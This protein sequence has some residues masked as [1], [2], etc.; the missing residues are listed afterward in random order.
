M[1][2]IALT[3]GWTWWHIYPLLALYNYLKDDK[4]L[5]FIWVWEQDSLEE[6][7]ASKAWIP[8]FDISAWKVRRYLDL[9]NLYEPLKNTSWV[10]QWVQIIKRQNIDLVFS[11]WWYVGLPLCIAAKLLWK[12]IY[13]HESDVITWATNHLIWNMAKKIFYTFPNEKIDWKKHILSGQ[14]INPEILDWLEDVE[15]EEN[16]FLNVLV[17]AGSQWSSRIFNSL[18][19]ILPNLQDIKF[20]VILW[21]KNLHYRDKFKNFTNVS[22]YDY[23]SQ[24]RLWKIYKNTDIA[25]TR[26]SSVIW[27]LYNFWIHSIIIPLKESANNHQTANAKYFNEKF[28]SDVILENSD[29]D[30]E[31]FTLIQ[32]YKDLRKVWLNLDNFFEPLKKI[33]KEIL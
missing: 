31:L 11:K 10:F 32:K 15:V 17:L 8:F 7:E 33:K 9:R 25:I 21:T 24:K 4:N 27:E 5:N 12:P 19:N 13:I 6:E 26:G 20:S 2:N 14:I 1:I 30:Q 29:I 3:W 28:W 22:V 23:V 18:L 16:D